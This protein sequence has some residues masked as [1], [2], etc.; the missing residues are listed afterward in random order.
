[1]AQRAGFDMVELH[2]AHGYLLSSFI[3]P[4]RT[5]APTNM[6]AA[7]RTACAI[8]SKSSPRCARRGRRTSRCRCAS[9]PTTG[10]ATT[11]SR[12]RTRS[13]SRDASGGGRRPDRRV[14]R[15]DLERRSRSTA[16][17]SRRRSATASATRPA[18]RPW[19][20]AT[21]T[22]PT[23][24]TRSSR[25]AA[26]TCAALARPHLV[27]PYWTLRAAAQLGYAGES[28][29][30]PYLAG[31]RPAASIGSRAPNQ[32]GE[33]VM[34]A[35][36]GKHALITGGGSGIG[37]AIA[38]TLAGAGAAVSI[39]GRRAGRWRRWQRVCRAPRRSSPM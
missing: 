32:P 22:S 23:T 24:P 13:R 14:G 27:D 5:S 21:S 11:A 17:C 6:A 25:P 19:R 3:T 34:A 16:A 26:P 29:P 7:S 10:P 18:S 33:G 9:R 28:W 31:P 35:L 8:R 38:R 2:G 30:K 37:A 4:L 20:S 36:A 1:M 15:P 39:T 12:R